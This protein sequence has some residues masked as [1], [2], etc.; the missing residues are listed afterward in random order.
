MPRTTRRAGE[1]RHSGHPSR[2]A[3]QRRAKNR[4]MGNGNPHH[5]RQRTHDV[6]RA[7]CYKV[8]QII[9]VAPATER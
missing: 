8:L 7:N 2:P 6:A 9:P 4:D 5:R 1:G 3:G